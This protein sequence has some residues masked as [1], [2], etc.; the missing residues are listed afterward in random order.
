MQK[1]A[2][3]PFIIFSW[4]VAAM[5]CWSS[6]SGPEPDVKGKDAVFLIPAAYRGFVHV[7]ANETCGKTPEKIDDVNAFRVP[8]NG[9]L[10]SQHPPI[11]SF[12]FDRFAFNTVDGSGHR[13]PLPYYRQNSTADENTVLVFVTEFGDGHSMGL[14]FNYLRAFVGTKSDIKEAFKGKRPNTGA[15][16]ALQQLKACRGN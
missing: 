13:S 2:I 1:S 6:C 10:I 3:S 5:L 9:V 7:Y 14:D 15:E 4:A 12:E 16:T 8:D 11:R